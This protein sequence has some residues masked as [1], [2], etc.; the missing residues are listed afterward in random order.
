MSPAIP[1]PRRLALRLAC[2]LLPVVA[3]CASTVAPGARRIE[4]FDSDWRFLASDVPAAEAP[5][6]D[7]AAWQRLSVPHDWSIAGEF[8]EE[9]PT[10]KQGGYLPAG[11]GWY[12]KTFTVPAT[13][14]ERRVFV[15]FDG[16][17]AN[18]D[19]W[20]NGHHLGH[21]PSGYV[22]L[23]YE[24]TG[25][26]RFGPG[27]PN[28]L[29]VRADNGPQPAS[30]WY[31]GAGIY[32][33]VRL[34]SL[35]PVHLEP[36]SVFVTTAALGDSSATV[37]V[38]GTIRNSS[39]RPAVAAPRIH[40]LDP[41]GREVASAAVPEL[42][43][44]GGANAA[45]QAD[46]TLPAPRRWDLDHPVLY[47][48]VVELASAGA[49]LDSETISFGVREMRFDAA[50]GF[51]LNGR[52]LKIQGVCLHQD[53]G[54]L[55]VA[56][57]VSIWRQ[58]LT[59]LRTFGVNAVR[60]AHNAMAPEFL[61]L[62]DQLGFLVLDEF[63]DCWNQAK[64]PYD[65]HLYFA[66]WAETDARETVRRD[67]NHPSIFAYSAGNEIHDT[68]EPELAKATLRR[69]L[70][71]YHAE[72]PT[73]PVTQALFRPNAT[74]DYDNGFADLLDVIGQNYREDELLAAHAQNPARKILGTEN[75]HD[76]ETWRA[77]RDNPAYAGQFLWP[78]IGYLGES[79]G[80]PAVGFPIGLLDRTGAPYPR[81][82]ERQS[83]WTTLPMVYAVR[84]TGREVTRQT[85]PGYGPAARF[86]QVVFPDWTPTDRSPH[87]ET[88]DVYSNAESVELFLN[89]RS[90]GLRPLPADAKPRVW[91]VPF[92]P[93]T[94]E[95][96]ARNGGAEVARHRLQTAGAAERL[97]CTSSADELARPADGVVTV[98]IGIMDA[99][100]VP[101]PTASPRVR[102]TLEGPAR[103]LGVDNADN[104]SHERFAAS[105]RSAHQGRCVAFLQITG[106]GPVT[107]TASA[108]GLE[109]L[110][111]K[112]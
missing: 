107:L 85:D 24:L 79:S 92:E 76:V 94:L 101:V 56:V 112:L 1:R 57:P 81:A 109:P 4:S 15:E 75:R 28:V 35:A 95:A 69:L 44:A 43:L 83:W 38:Q 45:W 65:Y 30:R 91:R 82:F 55:G 61:D 21:R 23:R 103:I 108:D 87:T 66:E 71:V 77:L 104:Q 7:D 10:G 102:F 37:R 16:V 34:L 48:A 41:D 25:H 51:W 32:R 20:I 53:A 40:L 105:E 67:R 11:I 78:G 29:A 62:C 64:Q 46:L 18:S 59:A 42:P 27:E 33:P 110:V 100:G 58:Q 54:A 88:V 8:R 9:H 39:D 106:P 19:V 74:H 73:R 80:W 14:R 3:A 86:R 63:F 90:L 31:S 60:T 13:D 89:G 111:Q 98:R 97:A 36:N 22:Q 2:V 93:G 68:R 52:N 49:V 47:R 26:L 96:V 84:R 5:T 72:D 12:R 99:H 17:M 70:A 50:T 6:F